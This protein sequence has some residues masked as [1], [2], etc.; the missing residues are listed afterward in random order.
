MVD[1][2]GPTVSVDRPFVYVIRHEPTGAA[3][4]IGAV[5]GAALAA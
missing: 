1:S 5:D 4:F 3:L 2:H